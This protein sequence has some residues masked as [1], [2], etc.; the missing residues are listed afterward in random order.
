MRNGVKEV[1]IK[2]YDE[3]VNIIRGKDEIFTDDLREDFV[4]RGL[5]NIEYELIPSALR[6]NEL[7]ELNINIFIESD[8]VFKV[9]I[10]KTEAIN[11]GLDYDEDD[12]TYDSEVIVLF[13]KYGNMI[14]IPRNLRIYPIFNYVFNIENI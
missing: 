7:N 12:L 3:L 1:L 11:N 8:Y 9:S 5:S 4:F 10:D 13:D 14:S 2:S 6:K